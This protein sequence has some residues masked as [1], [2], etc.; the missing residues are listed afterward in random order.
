[1]RDRVRGALIGL[2]VGDAVGTTV[3]FKRPGTF[4]PVT[5]MVGGGPFRLRPGEWTDAL[6]LAESLIECGGFDARDQMER[7]VKW[8][9][10]GYLSSTGKFFDIGNTTR[11]ALE[12]FVVTGD[13][14]SGST[15]PNAAGNGSLMRLGPVA[16]FYVG[17]PE[18]GIAG[19]SESSRTTHGAREAVDAYLMVLDARADSC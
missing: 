13:P 6:C 8:W 3:E 10:T 2:A 9:K 12:R 15:S 4:A 17:R 19:C 11:A 16:M 18:E 14:F 1:M 7:Y 5:D